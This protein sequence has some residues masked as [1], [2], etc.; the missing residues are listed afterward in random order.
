MNVGELIEKLTSM[1][2]EA[3]VYHSRTFQEELDDVMLFGEGDI[4]YVELDFT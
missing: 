3:K 4:A 2:T 1:P